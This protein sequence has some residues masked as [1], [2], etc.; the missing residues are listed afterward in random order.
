MISI[1]QLPTTVAGARERQKIARI[2][3]RAGKSVVN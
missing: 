1:V 3:D 2:L